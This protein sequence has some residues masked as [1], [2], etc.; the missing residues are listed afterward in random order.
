MCRADDFLEAGQDIQV[1]EG[2]DSAGH[3]YFEK[4]IAG[5]TNALE[6]DGNNAAILNNRGVAYF[7]VGK[8]RLSV[9]D[10][11]SALGVAPDSEGNYIDAW[12]RTY[13]FDA[14]E[15]LLERGRASVALAGAG[16]SNP[17]MLDQAI[18]DL[19]AVLSGEILNSWPDCEFYDELQMGVDVHIQLAS[20]YSIPGDI[21]TAIGIYSRV[22]AESP[23]ADQ[24]DDL[25]EL[26]G[27]ALFRNKEYAAAVGDLSKVLD[28]MP[29]YFKIHILKT[30]GQAHAALGNFREAINDYDAFMQE[31]GPEREVM[32]LQKMAVAQLEAANSDGDSS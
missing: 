6:V 28:L 14:E 27:E 18:Q 32:R 19:Q 21:D 3:E 1:L 23:N 7:A 2:D 11:G 9:E 15:C 17:A 5:Y 30:R 20:A 13:E 8:Y 4:A 29:G 10:H 12:G 26:R 16:D 22:I 24:W 31:Y 25:W